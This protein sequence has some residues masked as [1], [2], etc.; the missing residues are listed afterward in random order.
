MTQGRWVSLP[1]R[2]RQTGLEI[3]E[4]IEVSLLR[5]APR[6]LLDCEGGVHAFFIVGYA[7]IDDVA[8]EHVVS[9]I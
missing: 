3:D 4:D 2:V 7:S 5:R 8:K 9:L 6:R 1:N